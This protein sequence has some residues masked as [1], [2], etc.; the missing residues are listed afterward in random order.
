MARIHISLDKET[1]AHLDGL[2]RTYGL[3]RSL[4]IRNAVQEK[5]AKLNEAKP[6]IKVTPSAKKPKPSTSSSYANPFDI[7]PVKDDGAIWFQADRVAKSLGIEV[8]DMLDQL[9]LDDDTRLVG[10][11]VCVAALGV[12]T[13]LGLA[14]RTADAELIAKLKVWVDKQKP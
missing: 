2:I 12:N 8:S 9:D 11:D 10:D 13:A 3:N 5:L 14:S 7:Q 4:F 1:S 6:S